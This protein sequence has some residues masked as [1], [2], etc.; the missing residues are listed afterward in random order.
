MLAAVDPRIDVTNSEVAVK[1]LNILFGACVL[2][3]L[4]L[5]SSAQA[6]E[7][8]KGP[9][10]KDPLHLTAFGISMQTGI[11]GTIDVVIERWTTDQERQMLLKFVAESKA[12]F[13]S[14][15]EDL[16]SALQDIKPRVGFIRVPNRLGW[17]LK[18]A[19]EN[20]LP[21]GTRQIVVVTDKP[22]SF[23]AAKNNTRTMDYPFTLI[24]IHLN[25][26]NKGEGRMLAQTSIEVKNGRLELENYGQEPVRL[27]TVSELK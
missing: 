19:R 17:D 25:K 16:I 6:P 3:A 2:V 12:N 24:E 23:F 21:D 18:Y 26:E 8:R 5:P 7:Q 10:P 27:T 15:Q 1:R 13:R 14:G 11:K 22:V 20:A 4:T 9:T